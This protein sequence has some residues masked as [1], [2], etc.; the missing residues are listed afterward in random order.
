MNAPLR[1]APEPHALAAAIPKPASFS[2]LILAAPFSRRTCDGASPAPV[3]TASTKT[4]AESTV[5]R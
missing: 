4:G 5:K 1:P 2:A 3:G